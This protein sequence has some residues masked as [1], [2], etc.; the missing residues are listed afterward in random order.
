MELTSWS[1][2]RMSRSLMLAK[3]SALGKMRMAGVRHHPVLISRCMG[4]EVPR[5]HPTIYSCLVDLVRSLSL[6]ESAIS[7]LSRKSGNSTNS[8]SWY[9]NP[10]DRPIKRLKSQ[11]D[12]TFP[13][14][15]TSLPPENPCIL[16]ATKNIFGRLLNGIEE[17]RVCTNGSNKK[18]ATG[19]FLHIEQDSMA[20]EGSAYMGW[21]KAL[22]NVFET[23][24][25]AGMAM[26]PLTKL[27]A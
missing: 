12:I 22:K 20:R 14:W 24:C 6:H 11:L 9:T 8:K 3:R 21:T 27:C 16:T 10:T 23:T 2:S 7:L 4:R 25:M 15:T 1:L 26:D 17:S 19:E 5:V 13:T 18:L